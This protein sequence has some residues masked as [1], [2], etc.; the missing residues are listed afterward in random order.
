ME[1]EQQTQPSQPTQ[2]QSVAQPVTSPVNPA[3][4]TA[5]PATATP[6]LVFG[7][8]GLIAWFIPIIGLPVTIAAVVLAVKAIKLKKRFATLA[9]VLG[10][11]GLVLTII[12]G[13]IGAYMGA[14]GQL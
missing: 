10:I 5:A 12:N 4:V 14:T 11:I 6:A 9:L 1:P 3:P 8:L 2:A 7:G 13:S